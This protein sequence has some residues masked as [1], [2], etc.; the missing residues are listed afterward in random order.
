VRPAGLGSAE[1]TNPKGSDALED[2]GPQTFLPGLEPASAHFEAKKVGKK[3]AVARSG[4]R[5]T[6]IASR[7]CKAIDSTAG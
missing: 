1:R 7:F 5:S 3:L 4:T 6:A 2:A